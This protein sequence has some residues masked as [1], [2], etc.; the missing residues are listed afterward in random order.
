M[1]QCLKIS[2]ARGG[3][4]FATPLYLGSSYVLSF[5]GTRSDEAKKVILTKPCSQNPDDTD[6]IVVLA[7]SVN[8]QDKITLFLNRNVLVEWFKSNRACDVESTVDAHC[9][10][11]NEQGDVIADSPVTIEYSPTLFVI[12]YEDYPLAREVLLQ[13]TSARDEA[14]SAKD[15][16]ISAKSDA[17]KAKQIAEKAKTDAEM[18]STAAKESAETSS[19]ASKDAITAK[20]AAQDAQRAAEEKA[21]TAETALANM[22][23]SAKKVAGGVEVLLWNGQGNKPVPIFIPNGVDGVTGYVKCDEDGK[24]YCLKCKLVDGEKVLALEQ[25]G[26]DSIVQEGYVRAVNGSTPDETGNVEIPLEFLPLAGGKMTGPIKSSMAS[27]L[28]SSDDTFKTVLLCGG[29]GLNDGASIVLRGKNNSTNPGECTIRV[30]DGYKANTLRLLP[31]G[32]LELDGKAVTLAGDCLPLTGGTMRGPIKSSMGNFFIAG[33]KSSD[34]ALVS[35]GTGWGDGASITLRGRLDPT[36]PSEFVLNLNDGKNSIALKALPDGTFT[37]GGK[38]VTLAGDCLSLT[39]GGT[40]IGE[41]V[42]SGGS[43]ALCRDTDNG[44]IQIVGGRVSDKNAYLNLYGADYPRDSSKGSFT[45]AANN[46]TNVFRLVGKIDGSLTWG[47]NAVERVVASSFGSTSFY[48]KYESG[49]IIQGGIV[50]SEG[51]TTFPIPFSN[52]NYRVMLN[53]VFSGSNS[54]E[55]YAA[56]GQAKARTTTGF[57]MLCYVKSLSH[58]EWV[59]FGK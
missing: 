45:L 27:F 47:G 51:N 54:D 32:T 13:A 59:A 35:G 2:I 28:I 18:S 43:R 17:E 25:V 56:P 38:K 9:Y 50:G 23:A 48:I 44:A 5:E 11:F 58:V 1:N 57:R 22:V 15:S 7:Q 34:S 6:G 41:I 30:Y 52:T 26:V 8:E 40:I 36:N 37:W 29:T 4:R 39:E 46:G 16:V 21:S 3:C 49:L 12:D 10:V 42:K 24:Y 19:V 55:T 14:V 31:G 53:H 33:T 20:N